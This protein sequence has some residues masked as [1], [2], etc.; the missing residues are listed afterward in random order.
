MGDPK[1]NLTAHP[2][3][4]NLQWSTEAAQVSSLNELYHYVNRECDEAILWYFDKKKKKK[5]FGQLFR[6]GAIFAVAISGVIPIL[7][8]ISE[9]SFLIVIS[10]AWATVFLAVAALFVSL[11]R[12]GGCTSG[13]VRYIRTG[14]I[15]NRLQ[16]DFK[17]EWEKR[18][19]VRQSEMLNIDSVKQAIDSCQKFLNQVNSTVAAETDQWAQ[20]FQRALHDLES[21]AKKKTGAG[22]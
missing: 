10:P 1:H 16:A 13:W 7:S 19:L 8:Q 18:V 9:K 20:E 3:P 15:L 5:F 4:K 6:I 14:Q 12:F 2:F 17:F 21:N 22:S 11:D